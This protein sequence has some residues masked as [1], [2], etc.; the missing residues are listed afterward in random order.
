MGHLLDPDFDV[1]TLKVLFLVYHR[2]KP[3]ICRAKI[4]AKDSSK[5]NTSVPIVN[6]RAKSLTDAS[7]QENPF[8]LI[9]RCAGDIGFFK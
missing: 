3:I 1:E 7:N 5:L 9:F 8:N 4:V 6:D 2:T